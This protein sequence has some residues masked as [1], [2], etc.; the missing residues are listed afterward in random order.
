MPDSILLWNRKDFAELPAQA[1]HSVLAYI[2][3]YPS[4]LFR[5][6]FFFTKYRNVDPLSL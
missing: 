1:T 5:F 4:K 2:D 6:L 3:P